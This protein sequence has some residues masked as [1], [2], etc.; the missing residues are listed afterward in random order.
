M[1]KVKIKIKK[2]FTL[3]WWSSFSVPYPKCGH[4]THPKHNFVKTHTFD[5][6]LE[7]TAF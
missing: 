2:I 4:A 6:K 1:F 7:L 5:A 3:S